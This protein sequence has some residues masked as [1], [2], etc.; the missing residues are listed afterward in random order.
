[1]G[2]HGGVPMSQWYITPSKQYERDIKAMMKRHPREVEQMLVN[3]QRYH[4]NL[5]EHD[6]P[7]RMVEFSFVHRE[8]AGCH[9]IT[10]QPLSPATQTRLY[11][12]CYVQ[13]HEIHL[14]CAGDKHTQHDDNEYCK[15]YVKQLNN[16]K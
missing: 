8:A 14:I 9:A 4:Q 5:Q 13:D 6:N 15:K 16:G 3:L 1:M 12:Y 7:L 11:L 10:Q 2:Y